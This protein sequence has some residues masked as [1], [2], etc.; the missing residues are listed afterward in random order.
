MTFEALDIALETIRQLRDPLRM[1]ARRDRDLGNQLRRSLSSMAL[2]LAEGWRREGG[3]RTHLFRTAAGS[4]EES[5]AALRVA[6]AF[7]YLSLERLKRPLEGL[8]RVL[9][10]TW[11]LTH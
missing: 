3:D 11:R 1:L 4:A 2:T 7:G 5:R 6:D 9:A 10:I 8:D